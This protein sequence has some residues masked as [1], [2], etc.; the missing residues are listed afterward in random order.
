MLRT[1]E[2]R[3]RKDATFDSGMNWNARRTGRGGCGSQSTKARL[4]ATWIGSVVGNG[5]RER[6][7]GT[8]VE[9]GGGD[10]EGG[11]GDDAVDDAADMLDVSAGLDQEEKKRSPLCEMG[12]FFPICTQR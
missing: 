4:S 11:E 7:R 1:T 10:V 9:A 3:R 5:E 6:S 2:T 12:Y 8:A